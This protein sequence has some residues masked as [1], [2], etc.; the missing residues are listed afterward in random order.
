MHSTLKR[1][2]TEL[3]GEIE[4]IASEEISEEA[5]INTIAFGFNRELLNR[6]C[7]SSV[8]EFIESC[9]DLYKRK[10]PSVAMYFYSWLDEQAGQFRIC[11][12]SQNHGELP[13]RCSL[14]FV[15]LNEVVDGIYVFDSGLFTRGQLEV[16]RKNI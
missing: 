2:F 11:A 15:D 3:E 8:I 7:K 4:I 1:W 12:V 6:W 14:C 9:A 10:G 13:F 16:W 5:R